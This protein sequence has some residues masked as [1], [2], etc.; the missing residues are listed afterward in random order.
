MGSFLAKA[1]SNAAK[2]WRF[3]PARIGDKNVPG[4]YLVHF[5]FGPAT[6]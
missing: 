6:N 2:D 5:A 1:A 4:E 3:R